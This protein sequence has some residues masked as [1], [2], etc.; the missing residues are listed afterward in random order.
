VLVVDD[1]PAVRRFAAFVLARMGFEV[2]EAEDGPQALELFQR[3]ADHIRAV[4]LDLTMPR[5]SGEQVLDQLRKLRP[6]LPVVLS[7]GFDARDVAER[8]T[9][10][11]R[12][13][14]VQKPYPAVD[15]EDVVRRVLRNA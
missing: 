10:E 2:V 11:A 14:F 15:L 9:G 6:D 4:L 13:G 12:V 8:T 7:S 3:H 1:E 5:M